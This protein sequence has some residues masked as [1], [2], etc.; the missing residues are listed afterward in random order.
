[1]ARRVARHETA[2]RKAGGRRTRTPRRVAEQSEGN[3]SK[4]MTRCS[5]LTTLALAV[6]LCTPPF[7]QTEIRFTAASANVKEPGSPVKIH[8]IRWSTDEERSSMVAAL[9]PAA[10][11][12]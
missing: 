1:M 10:T 5:R 4:P 2:R 9:N 12:A 3:E 7:A 6:A 11:A 8:L